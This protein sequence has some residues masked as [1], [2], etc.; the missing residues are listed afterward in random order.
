M[1]KPIRCIRA[2]SD[3]PKKQL[4]YPIGDIHWG[5]PNVNKEKVRGYVQW[6]LKSKAWVILMGDL[7]ENST[8]ASVGAGVYEQII[9]P[10]QQRKEIREE[11]QPLVDAGL[12]LGVLTGNHEQ[13]TVNLTGEDPTEILSEIW[14][15]PYLK[16]GGF[17]YLTVGHARYTVYATHGGSGSASPAGK[18]NACVKLAN[19]F[20]ADLYLMGH[21]HDLIDHCGIRFRYN[22]KRKM[23][24]EVRKHFVLT[25][26]FLDHAG[27]YAQ[28][29]TYTPSKLG[30]PRIRFSGEEK[31][32]HV[33]L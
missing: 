32:I 12:V 7:I 1:T 28:M 8:R 10:A 14:G 17:F 11:L 21:V 25:G 33:S 29:K 26:S 27:S 16:Y 2:T 23:V 3:D 13:R 5:H 4:L 18:L 31:D 30:A 6:A 22:P 20:D 15:V 9:A 24:E 19:G